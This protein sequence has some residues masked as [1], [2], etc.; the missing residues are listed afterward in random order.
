MKK[1]KKK[2][3]YQELIPVKI[4]ELAN[5]KI[6]LIYLIIVFI[7]LIGFVYYLPE[8][9]LYYEE[10]YK[11]QDT[12]IE[13]QVPDKYV[14][15]PNMKISSD[16]FTINDIAYINDLMTFTIT[17]NTSTNFSFIDNN[18]KLVLYNSD[19]INIHEILLNDFIVEGEVKKE[20]TLSAKDLNYFKLER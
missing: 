11:K 8:A 3:E 20:I 1:N 15:T 17:N 5:K 6:G 19:N 12:I 16:F 13:N 7:I 18:Y 2:I 14:Y 9:V 10:N 4:G